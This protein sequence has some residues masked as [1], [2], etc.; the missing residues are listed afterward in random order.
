MLKDLKTSRIDTIDSVWEKSSLRQLVQVCNHH[1]LA[2]SFIQK[3]EVHFEKSS[4]DG[5]FFGPQ[6]PASEVGFCLS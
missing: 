1:F 3:L 6:F 2:G 5:V 4:S